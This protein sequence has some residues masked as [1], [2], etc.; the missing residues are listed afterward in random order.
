MMNATA[1]NKQ[2]EDARHFYMSFSLHCFRPLSRCYA[3]F[4]AGESN[5]FFLRHVICH[6]RKVRKYELA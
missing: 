2:E 6:S 5:D 4:I 3:I 1:H